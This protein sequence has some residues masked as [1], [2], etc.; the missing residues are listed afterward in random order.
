MRTARS[1]TTAGCPATTSPTSTRAGRSRRSRPPRR[2]RSPDSRSSCSSATPRP[3]FPPG[4]RPAPRVPLRRQAR[5]RARGRSTS[6]TSP[7][8]RAT[9]AAPAGFTARKVRRITANHRN[10]LRSL[11][12]V[13]EG[14]GQ[15]IESLA[16]NNL[17]ANTY[18]VFTSDNGFFTGEHRL[19][20]GK[21]LPYEPSLRVPLMIRGPGL[22]PGA[23]SA[24]LVSNV[25][26]APTILEWA[27]ADR[28]GPGRRP[29]PHP[30]RRRYRPSQPP[31]DLHR[32]QHARPP[33]PRHPLHR[34]PHRALEAGPLPQR[35]DRAL[36]P[37]ARPPGAPLPA[38]QPP[39][40]AHEALPRCA[41]RPATRTASE[42]SAERR[43]GAVPGPRR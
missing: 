38:S 24:E 16:A 9:S 41:P 1:S 25:D 22:T 23:R 14:V 18:F 28:F 11:L 2:S 27:G 19:Q 12:A 10:Q 40:L 15:I 37:A 20:K 8:S 5:C 31:P 39:L 43:W 13:D 32:G 42:P 26:L 33:L 7:T 34:N 30:V 35:R 29:L 36:R 21:Y 17:L 3:T 6:P 4:P